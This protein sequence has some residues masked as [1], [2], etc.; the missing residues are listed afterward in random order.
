MISNKNSIKLEIKIKN[1]LEY[2][3]VF[4]NL[5]TTLLNNQRSMAK[6]ESMVLIRTYFY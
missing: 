3:N 1:Y 2:S 4:G 6:K 5:D